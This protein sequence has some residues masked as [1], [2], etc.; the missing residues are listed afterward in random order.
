[1]QNLLNQLGVRQ[2]SKQHLLFR[3]LGDTP[4]QASK[5]EFKKPLIGSAMHH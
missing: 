5:C 3:D 1:M 2:V 4:P